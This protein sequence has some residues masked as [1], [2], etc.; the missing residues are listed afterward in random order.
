MCINCDTNNAELHKKEVRDKDEG[1]P[2]V[3][4]IDITFFCPVCKYMFNCVG[5]KKL[6]IS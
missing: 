3:E 2:D 4:F 1:F 5:A 6:N